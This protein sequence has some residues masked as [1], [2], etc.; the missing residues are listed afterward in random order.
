MNRSPPDPAIV[1][2]LLVCLRP[3]TIPTSFLCRAVKAQQLDLL[4]VLLQNGAPGTDMALLTACVWGSTAAVC[5]L[6][7]SSANTNG[8][9]GQFL[10]AAS[11][12]GSLEFRCLLLSSGALPTSRALENAAQCRHTEVVSALLEA[13]TDP[14]APEALKLEC[15]NCRVST[16]AL[17]CTS[18]AADTAVAADAT[19]KAACTYRH[20]DVALMVL[21]RNTKCLGTKKA[22]IW[23]CHFGMVDV[24]QRLLARG[25]TPL[26]RDALPLGRFRKDNLE[27]YQ[28]SVGG[29]CS[30]WKWRGG[31]RQ[32]WLAWK[33][34]GFVRLFWNAT[35]TTTYLPSAN[36][37]KW[38][39]SKFEILAEHDASSKWMYRGTPDF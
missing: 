33:Q 2:V 1:A 27:D 10:A 17:L 30:C 38:K 36:P 13:G 28:G 19:L 8:Y 18:G 29:A 25:A 7:A 39:R 6:L 35:Q 3:E 24:V 5:I 37:L 9:D 34:G 23:V 32:H 26:P 4:E 15:Q 20:D 21:E 14:T 16:V 22:L 11:T 12:N 31:V